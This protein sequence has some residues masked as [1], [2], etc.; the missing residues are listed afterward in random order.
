M[1]GTLIEED[2]SRSDS[3]APRTPKTL[4]CG[5]CTEDAEEELGCVA[6]PLLLSVLIVVCG[7]ASLLL[8]NSSTRCEVGASSMPETALRITG[9]VLHEAVLPDPGHEGRD[10]D[11]PADSLGRAKMST[12]TD[13]RARRASTTTHLVKRRTGRPSSPSRRRRSPIYCKRLWLKRVPTVRVVV[14]HQM[15]RGSVSSLLVSLRALAQAKAATAHYVAVAVVCAAV[16]LVGGRGPLRRKGA[17]SWAP[18]SWASVSSSLVRRSAL[19]SSASKN[20]SWWNRASSPLV[21]VGWEGLW[22]FVL[23]H[24]RAGP[25]ADARLQRRGGGALARGLRRNVRPIGPF[26]R[27]D[28]T[29]RARVRARPAPLQPRGQYGDEA[30]VRGRAEHPGELPHAGRLA[31][32]RSFCTTRSAVC[33]RGRVRQWSFLELLAVAISSPERWPTRS[34]V[35]RSAAPCFPPPSSGVRRRVAARAGT[36]RHWAGVRPRGGRIYG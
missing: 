12:E 3:E 25:V 14:D 36:P 30:T 4:C 13:G 7:T 5:A 17:Q 11:V 33:Q 18:T 20:I 19:C 10:V 27:S 23:R 34:H 6:G 16:A 24:S 31:H 9:G 29:A 32:P 21:L 1:E 28:P 8:A 26:G 15:T 2:D 35:Q 22:V